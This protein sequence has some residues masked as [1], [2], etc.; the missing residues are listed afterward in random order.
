MDDRIP[1]YKLKL[2]RERW[3]ICPPVC[4][5]QPQLAAAFFQRLIGQADRGCSCG[6]RTPQVGRLRCVQ[7]RCGQWR[8]PYGGT[9]ARHSVRRGA[10]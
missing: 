10:V 1:L 6:E 2:H 5:D 8:R 9:R 3:T 4:F 7:R